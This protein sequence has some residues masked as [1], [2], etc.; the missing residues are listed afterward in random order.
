[1]EKWVSCESS[2]SRSTARRGTPVPPVRSPRPLAQVPH[3][4][5]QEDH[6]RSKDE[7][8]E[9]QHTARE[10]G[11]DSGR[12]CLPGRYRRC[13]IEDRGVGA[14]DDK[15]RG[16]TH[17]NGG[18][19]APGQQV[20]HADPSSLESDNAEGSI[21]GDRHCYGWETG[22]ID[23]LRLSRQRFGNRSNGNKDIEYFVLRI[24]N[25]DLTGD[26]VVVHRAERTPAEQ[27]P[28]PGHPHQGICHTCTV[29]STLPEAKGVP[30]GDHATVCTGW[31]CPW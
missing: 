20:E 8:E 15:V 19:D 4:D 18:E 27:S 25:V 2:T 3:H 6:E 23:A 22:R 13:G 21:V 17:V 5:E 14:G 30:S 11:Y 10:T 31:E 9:Q 28:S 7:Q 26:G 29:L 16:T 24:G 1:M 12:V